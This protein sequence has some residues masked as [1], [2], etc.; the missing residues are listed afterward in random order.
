MAKTLKRNKLLRIQTL[1]HRE[2][3]PSPLTKSRGGGQRYQGCWMLTSHCPSLE[4]VPGPP[5]LPLSLPCFSSWH[6]EM[7]LFFNPTPPGECR[8]KGNL[9]MTQPL[10]L[11]TPENNWIWKERHSVDF[12]QPFKIITILGALLLTETLARL[13]WVHILVPKA[14]HIV[15][16]Q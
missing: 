11:H 5:S 16:A 8:A 6:F 9:L 7:Y 2:L 15:G 4:D 13:G 1:R 3:H 14:E 12:D 10:L